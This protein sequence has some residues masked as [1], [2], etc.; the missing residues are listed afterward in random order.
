ANVW[1]IVQEC[2]S[3][4]FTNYITDAPPS[5]YAVSS[6][7]GYSQ[8]QLCDFQTGVVAHKP[9][10][11]SSQIGLQTFNVAY[12]SKTSHLKCINVVFDYQ[13]FFRII[14]MRSK[15][16][17]PFEFYFVERDSP[18]DASFYRRACF[19]DLLIQL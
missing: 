1:T 7:D 15:M 2:G 13:L 9:I 17:L 18:L 3:A 19:Q 4:I 6:I 14:A 11:I 10:V 8:S 12:G 5:H 16:K